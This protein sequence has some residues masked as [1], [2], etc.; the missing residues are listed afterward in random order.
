[1]T[2]RVFRPNKN[3]WTFCIEEEEIQSKEAAAATTA[4]ETMCITLPHHYF[5]K[6]FEPP[7]ERAKAE[8]RKNVLSLFKKMPEIVNYK[9]TK[10]GKL[11]AEWR[12]EE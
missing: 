4:T 8:Q 11:N 1:M 2:R 7:A 10:K 5:T 6:L 9:K 12:G 3:W